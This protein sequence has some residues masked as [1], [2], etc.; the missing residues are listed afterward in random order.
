MHDLRIPFLIRGPGIAGHQ[1]RPE[2]ITQV[3]Y[4]P[5]FLGYGSIG[6]GIVMTHHRTL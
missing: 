1:L 2:I 5:T 6:I 4:A 3:D